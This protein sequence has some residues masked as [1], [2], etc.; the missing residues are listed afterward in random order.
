[1][2]CQAVLQLLSGHDMTA[3][4]DGN[5]LVRYTRHDIESK[6]TMVSSRSATTEL[7]KNIVFF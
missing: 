5:G 2:R 4:D 6:K 1:M 3:N 7:F